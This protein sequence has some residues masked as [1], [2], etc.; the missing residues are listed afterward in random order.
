MTDRPLPDRSN[1][2]IQFAHSAYAFAETFAKRNTGIDHFQTWTPEDTL[3]RVDEADVLVISG[4][5]RGEIAA[6][7]A[8]LRFI[9][10]LSVGFEQF[11]LDDLQARGI[12]MANGSGVNKNAVSEQAMALVLALTRQLHLARDNQHKKHWRGMISD[13]ALREEELGGKTMVIYGLGDIGSRLA[14]LA[15]A[16][17]M[18][19]IGIKRDTSS[20]DGSAHEVQA[21][22]A[23]LSVLPQADFVVLACPLTAETRGLI[24]SETLAAMSPHARLI[25]V[26][27]GGCVDEEALIAALKSGQIAGAGLDTTSEEPLPDGSP[28]WQM[29]NVV[30]TPHTAGETERYEE[31][32]LDVLME[33]LDRLWR[34]ELPLRNQK[35]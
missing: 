18:H 26:A 14:R 3:D 9:Q 23:F 35:T 13:I 31:N 25:N 20:H 12:H 5:W 2:T 16:F 19:V 17:D 11:D 1:L 4:F 27:R 6:R 8:R 22:D 28:L 34:N 29:E 24:G 30:L 33:N 7:A 15:R 21:P 10:V 32:L